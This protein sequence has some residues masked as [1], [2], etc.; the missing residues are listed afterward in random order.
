MTIAGDPHFRL[1]L[2]NTNPSYQNT[3]SSVESEN[4]MEG[5]PHQDH[6]VTYKILADENTHGGTLS[7]GNYVVFWEDRVDTD[8]DYNDL[9]VEMYQ[10]APVPEPGTAVLFGLLLAGGALVS[11]VRARRR[12]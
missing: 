6:M 4:T 12:T 9:V 3:F 2:N 1:Y 7:A 5:A 11:I 10:V 8:Y